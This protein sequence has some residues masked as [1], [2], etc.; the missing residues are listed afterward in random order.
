MEITKEEI[1]RAVKIVKGDIRNLKKTRNQFERKY[2]NQLRNMDGFSTNPV[3]EYYNKLK[4]EIAKRQEQL[5]HLKR[6]MCDLGVVKY[7]KNNERLTAFAEEKGFESISEYRDSLVLKAPSED[8]LREFE[9]NRKRA[10]SEWF[11]PTDGWG[12][13]FYSDDVKSVDDLVS[14]GR[15]L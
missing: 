2:S 9:E 8:F 3:H 12:T 13:G 6:S 1:K 10:E 14:T 5:N 7:G 15:R 4:A 11:M